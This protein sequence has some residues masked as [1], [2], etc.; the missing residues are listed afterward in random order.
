[1][2]STCSI[3]RASKA[4]PPGMPALLTSTSQRPYSRSTRSRTASTCPRSRTSQETASA[5]PPRRSIASTSPSR[6]PFRLAVATTVE[7]ALENAAAVAQPI[8]AE[9]PVT[10]T[11]APR[12]SMLGL[13]PDQVRRRLAAVDDQ[14]GAGDE[15]RRR[16]AQEQGRRGDV[17]DPS[18]PAE[19]DR[20]QRAS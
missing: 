8:P 7:P 20:G 19:G 5:R 14:H 17:L 18:P 16:R 10:T 15:R 9:A 3:V 11:T 2:D 12:S 6:R 1:M 4:P 13:Q